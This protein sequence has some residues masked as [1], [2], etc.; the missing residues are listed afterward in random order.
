VK[1]VSFGRRSRAAAHEALG[2]LEAALQP[3][4][5][6]GR[7]RVPDRFNF[8]RDVVEVLAEDTRRR[9]LLFL[10][11]DGVIEPWTFTRLAEGAGSWAARLREH[12][13]RPGDRVVVVVGKTPAWIEVMLAGMKIGAVTVP[14]SPALSYDALDVRVVSSGA[15]VVVADHVPAVETLESSGRATV[16]YVDEADDRLQRMPGEEPTHET[17][18]RDLAFLLT[19]SGAG[20]GPYGVEHTH[21]G[22][23]AARAQ[24]EHWLDARPGDVVWCTAD[25]SSPL[26]VW[27]LLLGP[28]ARGAE[29]VLHQGAFDPAERLDLIRRFEVT[30]LCQSPGEYRALAETGERTLARYLPDRLR[31]M[32]STGDFLSSDV[33][34]A[35]ELAW[36]LPVED[37]WAQTECGVVIGHGADDGLDN[38]SVGHPLP[39]HEI[40]IVDDSGSELLPGNEGRLA[41]KGRPPTLFTG[42][43]NEPEE[44]RA[45]FR[46]DLYLTGDLAIR[47]LDGSVRLLG[48]ATDV[49]TSGGRSFSPFEVEQELVGHRAVANAGVVGIRDLQRGGHYVRAFVVLEAGIAGSD[50][51][52]AEIRQHL[53]HTLPEDMVPREVEFVDALPT[54]PNGTIL[55]NELRDWN[56]VAAE[57]VW[58]K[59]PRLPG[60]P[61]PVSTFEPPPEPR[62]PSVP[63]VDDEE[64][65]PDFVVHPSETY[66]ASLLGLEDEPVTE[67]APDEELPDY[68]V[69]PELVP[70]P[71]PEHVVSFLNAQPLPEVPIEPEREREPGPEPRT[72]PILQPKAAKPPTTRP[73]APPLPP[74]PAADADQPPRPKPRTRP[75]RDP[76]PRTAPRPAASSPK[77]AP[78]PPP[79]APARP[80]PEPV[81]VESAPPPPPPTPPAARPTPPAPAPKPAPVARKAAPPPPPPPA[82]PLPAPPAPKP[83]PPAQTPPAPAAEKPAPPTTPAAKPKPA[84][85]KP[86]TVPTRARVPEAPPPPKPKPASKPAAKAPAKPRPAPKPPAAAEPRTVPAEPNIPRKRGEITTPEPTTNGEPKRRGRRKRKEKEPVQAEAKRATVQRSAPEPGMENPDV[87]FIKD[88]SSR[89]SAYSIS[90][91][92]ERSSPTEDEKET[93]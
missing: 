20:G 78:P 43:W 9:A 50:R 76:D 5:E 69:V 48:R 39:G 15:K 38:G 36:G 89:L 31:R 67:L 86:A 64:P 82:P 45:V 93:V 25:T 46:G 34:S 35:F 71:L 22:A 88:L 28:W 68:I 66:A 13:V 75:I 1:L 77:P 14:C 21:G 63:E 10:G 92:K 65:L 54:A 17:A 4:W 2:P 6:E 56:T 58:A 83:K 23:F 73:V 30:I 57:G 42:Y 32:V 24:A 3:A 90:A 12:G 44:T 74:A 52:V 11:T 91:E 53:R 87:D 26:A 47:D 41:L 79:A 18:S 40:A 85:K 33:V 8:T 72:V 37:G 61:A 55:R 59:A 60:T 70:E 7:W 80:A 81:A 29:I 16:L 62:R 49:V 84:A 27:L 51:L 19:T